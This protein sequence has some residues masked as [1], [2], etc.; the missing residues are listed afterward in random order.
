[1]AVAVLFGRDSIRRKHQLL[2][3]KYAH[4]PVVE[5]VVV[6]LQELTQWF[7]DKITLLWLVPEE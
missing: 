1:V 6:L 5:E 7:Q 2:L 4:L 3:M